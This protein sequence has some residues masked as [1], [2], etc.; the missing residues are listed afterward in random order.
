MN[1]H[2][3]ISIKLYW[4]SNLWARLNLSTRFPT[5]TLK[6]QDSKQITFALTKQIYPCFFPTQVV[7]SNRSRRMTTH[8]P[9][10]GFPVY[11][12]IS[13]IHSYILYTFG[14]MMIIIWWY[15]EGLSNELT[16][17]IVFWSLVSMALKF[18][19]T[20]GSLQQGA[21]LSLGFLRCWDGTRVH[22][23]KLFASQILP[24]PTGGWGVEEQ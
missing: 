1:G 2:S 22:L 12:S 23:G 10:T 13:C 15:T 20:L 11:F 3:Y 5:S 24:Q 19:Q 14:G 7:H 6:L 4:Q 9:R 17:S 16:Q 18:L 8:I 21:D